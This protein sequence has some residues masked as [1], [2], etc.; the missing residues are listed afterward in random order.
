[1]FRLYIAGA[2]LV[3]IA[4]LSASTYI[5]YLKYQNAGQRLE[6]ALA[7]NRSNTKALRELRLDRQIER[8]ITRK[9]LEAA[10]SRAAS[11]DS[12]KKDMQNVEGANDI[13][14]PYFD[15]LGDRLRSLDSGT[16]D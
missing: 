7:V 11:I 14:A 12:V 13:V 4:G 3:L 1:M 8:E 6:Q 9:E 10:Q 5:Y 16:A 2:I 15:E